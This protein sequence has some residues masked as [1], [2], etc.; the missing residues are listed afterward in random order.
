MTTET[1]TVIS[2]E[3][4]AE[5]LAVDPKTVVQMIRAGEL[6]GYPQT[7]PGGRIHAWKVVEDSIAAYQR[8][9]LA[10]VPTSRARKGWL[11]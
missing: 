2:T 3:R 10:K 7:T 8:R 5:H 11:A 4:A 9:Q 1:L 6:Q